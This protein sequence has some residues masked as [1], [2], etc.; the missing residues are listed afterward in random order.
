MLKSQRYDFVINVFHDVKHWRRCTDLADFMVAQGYRVLIVTN[1]D[2]AMRTVSRHKDHEIVNIKQMA[3]SLTIA[4]ELE[5]EWR[6]VSAR[7]DLDQSINKFVEIECV[8][9]L[10][11]YHSKQHIVV[12][13]IKLFKAYET[14]FAN[15]E[16]GC[17][18]QLLASDIERHVFFLA[19]KRF[20]RHSVQYTQSVIHVDQAERAFAAYREFVRHPGPIVVGAAAGASV[21]G[22]IYEYACHEGNY[23][24]PNILAGAR[25]Q[26]REA[27]K[28]R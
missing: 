10:P 19:G 20:A 3:E 4:G 5:A 1:S 2:D 8:Q 15:A 17:F 14:L 22:P 24:L 11:S 13:T 12:Y 6:E 7:Y 23:S 27:G 18:F 25:V 16:V 28:G 21:L 26:E 9:N